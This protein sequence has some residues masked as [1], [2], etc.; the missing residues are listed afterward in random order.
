ME[1]PLFWDTVSKQRP[2]QDPLLTHS[3]AH[4]LSEI[5][6]STTANTRSIIV[7]SCV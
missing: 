3:L 6:L 4:S 7:A 5:L 1:I 2:A